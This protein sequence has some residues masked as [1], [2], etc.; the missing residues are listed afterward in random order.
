MANRPSS[1]SR[2]KSKS[3]K[4]KSQKEIN[5]IKPV[6]TLSLD[7]LQSKSSVVKTINVKMP[8]DE[9][10]EFYHKPA[11]VKTTKDFVTET[12][13]INR[14]VAVTNFITSLLVNKD[15][16]PF[17]EDAEDLDGVSWDVLNAI[18]G[19]INASDREEPGE[20]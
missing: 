15:G 8:D 3:S 12:T 6:G 5:R 20:D 14:V 2:S 1:S 13:T 7:V 9:I 17:I 16:T 18:H 10:Y 19:A 11:T 4:P